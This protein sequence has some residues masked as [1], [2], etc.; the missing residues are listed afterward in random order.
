[1]LHYRWTSIF[2]RD[3]D[4][5]IDVCISY[6]PAPARYMSV[7]KTT[8][9]R[10]LSCGIRMSTNAE[11]DMDSVNWSNGSVK[12]WSFHRWRN[13]FAPIG[14]N[15]KDRP[16]EYFQ[17][18]LPSLYPY[19]ENLK[20]W[21]KDTP[22]V[23]QS[24]PLKWWLGIH[25]AIGWN[26]CWCEPFGDHAPLQVA[27]LM[28]DR[29]R[30]LYGTLNVGECWRCISPTRATIQIWRCTSQFVVIMIHRSRMHIW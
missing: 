24:L 20:W 5:C 26:V 30:L 2:G 19:L 7:F 29:L 28:R 18:K 6:H 1:M 12:E 3:R 9:T 10:H 22:Q 23:N 13:T 16:S 8:E 25:P 14:F 27:S 17:E 4:E 11:P 15:Q 21:E